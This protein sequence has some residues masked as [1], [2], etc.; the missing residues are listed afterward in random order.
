MDQVVL[1][2]I[3]LHFKYDT[4]CVL[5]NLT[6]HAQLL[7]RTVDSDHSVKQHVALWYF[8]TTYS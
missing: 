8:L 7:M 6:S 1:E 3:H 5:T 4:E 2:W